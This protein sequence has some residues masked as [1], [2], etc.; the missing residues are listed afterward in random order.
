MLSSMSGWGSSLDV[1]LLSCGAMREAVCSGA[2]CP[3]GR[4]LDV[5][6]R[7]AA[8]SLEIRSP[9]ILRGGRTIMRFQTMD[10]ADRS[11]LSLSTLSFFEHALLWSTLS[12]F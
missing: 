5:V 12:F 8:E 4:A 6:C 11:T 2:G 1:P 10:R 9:H 3:R 7:R